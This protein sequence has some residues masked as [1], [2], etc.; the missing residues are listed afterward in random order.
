MTFINR[1]LILSTAALAAALF[2]TPG[3]GLPTALG[4]A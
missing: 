4:V 2:L 3:S 1:K